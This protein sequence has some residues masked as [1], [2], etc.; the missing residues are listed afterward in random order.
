MVYTPHTTKVISL[1]VHNEI[2]IIFNFVVHEGLS[3]LF[4][5][6]IPR[7]HRHHHTAP[8]GL[9][10]V[11]CTTC[12]SPLRGFFAPLKSQ[13]VNRKPQTGNYSITNF[14]NFAW[15][16]SSWRSRLSLNWPSRRPSAMHCALK[17]SKALR[18]K[19]WVTGSFTR[20]ESRLP[21]YS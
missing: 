10:G 7:A 21:L 9:Y 20:R 18:C 17:V 15:R 4:E 1:S 12:V 13:T 16:F 5:M 11:N 3:H 14:L 6:P 8:L 2:T 19:R